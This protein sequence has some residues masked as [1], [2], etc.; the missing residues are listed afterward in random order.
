VFF[1]VVIAYYYDNSSWNTK[2]KIA[3]GCI[4][5]VSTTTTTNNTTTI[6]Q[7]NN[8]TN[9][10]SKVQPNE[11]KLCSH[12][13]LLLPFVTFS[14]S[15]RTSNPTIK[16]IKYRKKA[17]KR[18]NS[19]FHRTSKLIP[20]NVNSI[21]DTSKNWIHKILIYLVNGHFY[22]LCLETGVYKKVA[23]SISSPKHP[24]D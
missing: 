19:L 10:L 5:T 16:Q 12:V 8:Q 23:G 11:Q 6:Q 21:R 7:Y 22:W 18:K 2:Q 3:R 24:R 15:L 1:Q 13:F 20:M 4:D 17:E 9:T 14:F